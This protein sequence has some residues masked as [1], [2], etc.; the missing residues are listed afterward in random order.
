MINES[1]LKSQQI[2]V[3]NAD[4]FRLHEEIETLLSFLQEK[5]ATAARLQ[6]ELQKHQQVTSTPEQL[7][8]LLKLTTQITKLEHRLQEAEHKK[9]Q[10][11]LEK[12][13]MMKEMKTRETLKAQIHAQLGKL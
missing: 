12:E 3:C 13:A 10:A 9:L 6:S 4:I 1:E 5:E 7:L 2:E 11:E 8:E